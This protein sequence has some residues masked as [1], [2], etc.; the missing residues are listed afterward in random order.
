MRSSLR[1]CIMEMHVSSGAKG[2]CK[3]EFLCFPTA[4]FDLSAVWDTASIID[5]S[6]MSLGLSED[7]SNMSEFATTTV[8]IYTF[9]TPSV[10]LSAFWAS[11]D[12]SPT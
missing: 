7:V 9:T 2:E 12:S 10:Y 11:N 6:D 4:R 3:M 1:V 8:I 5:F